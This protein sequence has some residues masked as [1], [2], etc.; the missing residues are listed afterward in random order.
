MV[1]HLMKIQCAFLLHL[2]MVFADF[3]LLACTLVYGSEEKP[4]SV[5][6]KF[7]FYEMFHVHFRHLL[8]LGVWPAGLMGVWRQVPIDGGVVCDLSPTSYY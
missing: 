1:D 4:F 8:L 7:Q 3:D 6:C 5:S 2:G